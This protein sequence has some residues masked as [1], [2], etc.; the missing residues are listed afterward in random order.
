MRPDPGTVGVNRCCGVEV[1]LR[2]SE[3]ERV[4]STGFPEGLYAPCLRAPKTILYCYE[5]CPATVLFSATTPQG[6][7]HKHHG[8]NL[9]LKPFLN[10]PYQ[11]F[12]RNPRA[13]T[14]RCASPHLTIIGLN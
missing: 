2:S 10:D 14:L 1:V 3:V 9:E 8:P 13:G 11:G 5:R 6:V 12:D 4:T 7:V